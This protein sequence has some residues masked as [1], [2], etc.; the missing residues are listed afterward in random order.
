MR[1]VRDRDRAIE[2]GALADVVVHVDRIRALDDPHHTAEI[3][4]GPSVRR[5]WSCLENHWKVIQQATLDTAAVLG[6]VGAI[7]AIEVVI[8]RRLVSA[9]RDWSGSA[10]GS[11]LQERL[12]VLPFLADPL[13]RRRYQGRHPAIGRL[14]D[15][16]GAGA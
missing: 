6:T 3:A 13:L 11:T 10:A 2:P 7:H 16:R 15:H 8:G 4:E 5:Q 1:S 14:D 9:R 12:E